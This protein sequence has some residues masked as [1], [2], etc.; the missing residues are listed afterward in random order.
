MLSELD[1]LIYLCGRKADWLSP[2]PQ[3]Q[4][5]LPEA[6]PSKKPQDSARSIKWVK[7]AATDA[8]SSVEVLTTFLKGA[9]APTIDST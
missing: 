7:S 4:T 2:A 3:L 1:M 8:N 5:P 9:D 6:L